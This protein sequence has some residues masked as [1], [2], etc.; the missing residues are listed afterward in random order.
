MLFGEEGTELP[1]TVYGLLAIATT[2]LSGLITLFIKERSLRLKELDDARV[3]LSTA[4]QKVLSL[5]VTISDLRARLANVEDVK[6]N[7]QRATN[8]IFDEWK[9]LLAQAKEEVARLSCEMEAKE[10]TI[11]E[12]RGRLNDCLVKQKCEGGK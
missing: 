7:Q 11:A 2:A 6:Q 4:Q 3:A 5:E 10:V 12:L 1:T 8:R 9:A